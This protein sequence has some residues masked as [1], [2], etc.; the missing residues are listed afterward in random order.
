MQSRRTRISRQFNKTSIALKNKRFKQ[1]LFISV[2]QSHDCNLIYE[3]TERQWQRQVASMYT[4]ESMVMHFLLDLMLGNLGGG[5]GGAI[6]NLK[7][8]MTIDHCIGA[9]AARCV[10]TIRKA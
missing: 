7:W 6:Q 1:L 2:L 5:G 3:H 4:I 10:H 8:N 9:A